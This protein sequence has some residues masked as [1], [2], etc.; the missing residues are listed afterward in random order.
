MSDFV[1]ILSTINDYEKARDISKKLLEDK[2]IACSNIVPKITSVYCWKGE[3]CEDGECLMLMKSRRSV[4]DN[5]KARISE[6]HPYEVPEIIAIDI[7]DG[8]S[9]YLNWIKQS[10]I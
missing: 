4:F 7:T 6:L 9:D 5:I 1:L 3:I 2:L 10:L 8:T